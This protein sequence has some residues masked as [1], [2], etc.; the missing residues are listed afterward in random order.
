VTPQEKLQRAVAL[1]FKVPCSAIDDR[2]GPRRDVTLARHVYWYLL[3]QL[4]G[5]PPRRSG[6]NRSYMGRYSGDWGGAL[7]ARSVGRDKHTVLHAVRKIE[8]LRDDAEFDARIS[9]LEAQID[10]P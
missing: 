6:V 3:N 10:T 7:L 5:T 9:A 2:Y 1:E 4:Q 8:D